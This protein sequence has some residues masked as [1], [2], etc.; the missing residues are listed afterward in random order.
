VISPTGAIAFYYHSLNPAKHVEKVLA[1]V[2]ELPPA[3]K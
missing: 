2:K 1:A 3:K